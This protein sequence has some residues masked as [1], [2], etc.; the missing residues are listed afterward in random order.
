[1]R[2]SVFKFVAFQELL[3]GETGYTVNEPGQIALA[4]AI[5]HAVRSLIIEGALEGLWRFEDQL[6]GKEVTQDY[7]AAKEDDLLLGDAKSGLAQALLN[8]DQ[9]RTLADARDQ[10]RARLD[11]QAP[12]PAQAEQVPKPAQAEQAP[13]PA[14]AEQMP[15][16]AR[17]EQ[18]PKPAQAEKVEGP[19]DPEPREMTPPAAPVSSSAQPPEPEERAPAAVGKQAPPQPQRTA[20]I[21]RPEPVSAAVLV[22]M[23][24]EAETLS[25]SADQ[26]R[27]TR[28]RPAP[29]DASALFKPAAETAS[30]PAKQAL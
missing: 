3:E 17:A 8:E 9:L 18:V 27:S 6:A 1:M 30:L 12:K 10:R 25:K 24:A 14:R 16:P 29:G 28:N 22:R 23:A 5:E 26:P 2:G 4:Q 21:V 15:E 11:A 19:S 13:E 20:G 7:L